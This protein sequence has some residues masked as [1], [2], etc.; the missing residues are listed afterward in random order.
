MICNIKYK[1]QTLFMLTD[2]K[3][4]KPRGIRNVKMRESSAEVTAPSMKLKSASEATY[5]GS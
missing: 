2:I 5:D 4:M 1:P 3:T